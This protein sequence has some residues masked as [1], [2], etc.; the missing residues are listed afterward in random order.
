[1]YNEI[2]ETSKWSESH[3]AESGHA[4]M[5]AIYFSLPYT[6]RAD[7]CVCLGSGAGFVPK[8]MHKAQETL[9]EEKIIPEINITLIDANIGIW[10]LPVYEDSIPNYPDIKLIKKLTDDAYSDVSNIGY[11][12]VDADHTYEQVYKDLTNYGS[13]MREGI[14]AITIHDTNN[15]HAKIAGM[16]LGSYEASVDWARSN[17]HDIVNFPVGCGTALI[18]PKVGV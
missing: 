17:G 1:L 3:G 7:V 18:M 2:I 9:I 4:G 5:G 13:R 8:L 14:W 12:H 11:L 6:L 10:G 16:P 15:I